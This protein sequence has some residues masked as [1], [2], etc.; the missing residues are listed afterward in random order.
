MDMGAVAPTTTR[1]ILGLALLVA[2][3]DLLLA[4]LNSL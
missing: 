2:E 1:D 4:F 3:R